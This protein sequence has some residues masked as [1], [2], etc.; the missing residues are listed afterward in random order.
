[1]VAMNVLALLNFL[2]LASCGLS[3]FLL[4]TLTIMLPSLD[5]E[6]VNRQS[7]S[8][9]IRKHIHSILCVWILSVFLTIG[10]ITLGGS[11]SLQSMQPII[12]CLL[13]FISFVWIIW[14]HL[15]LRR[16]DEN[17]S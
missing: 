11:V 6:F 3:L 13:L 8:R 2:A 7:F 16:S 15:Y 4:V 17:Q 14:I 1:M 12:Q 9:Y 5:D 10:A